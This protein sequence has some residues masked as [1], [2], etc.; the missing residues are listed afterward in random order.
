M[1]AIAVLLAVLAAPPPKGALMED[2][3]KGKFE[4]SLKPQP[5]SD[6]ALGRMSID[7]SFHG[8]LE[9]VSR[10][11]MLSAGSPAT[12]SAGYVA[13]EF[14]TGALKGRKGGFALQHSGTMD[15]GRQGLIVTVAPGSGTGDLVGLSGTMT[16][17]VADGHAYVL[18]YRLPAR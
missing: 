16:I 15:A 8:D 11:E 1:L 17:D 7:K 14:V 18:R 9:A 12:G 4:V 2:E 13:M 3:A 10:G 5:A 6:P